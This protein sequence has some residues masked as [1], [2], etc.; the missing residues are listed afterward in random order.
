MRTM[1]W[2]TRSLLTPLMLVL[3]I[4][5]SA[6]PVGATETLDQSQ[7]VSQSSSVVSASSQ[8]AQVFT[9]GVYGNLS[10]V[11]LLLE[12]YVDNPPAGAFL[13]VGV[14]TVIGGLPSGKQIGSG[15]VLLSAVGPLGSA[16]WVDVN[17]RSAVVN[18]GAQ[19]ALVLQTSPWNAHV[20]WWYAYNTNYAG[21]STV[22]NDGTAWGVNELYDFTFKTYVIPD[23]L[24]QACYELNGGV[25]GNM[26]GQTFTPGLSGTLDRVRVYL[27]NLTA[28]GTLTASIQTVEKDGW[29]PSRVQIGG[30]SVPAAAIPHS[31][32]GWVE[33]GISGAVLNAGTKYAIVL[34][35]QTGMFTW[36]KKNQLY[37]PGGIM[38]WAWSWNNWTYEVAEAVFETYIATPLVFAP[39]PPPPATITPCSSGVCP[40]AGGLI[41]P[42]DSPAR[43]TSLV[44]FWE[45]ANGK[46]QGMLHFDDSRT[47]D[48]VLKGCGT[49]SAAC[50]LTVE[51]FACTDEHAI[52]IGGTY[53]PKKDEV[54][55]YVLTMSGVKKE[56]GTFAL[57]TGDYTYTVTHKGIVDV[58][59]PPAEGVAGGRRR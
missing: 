44:Q 2:M 16:G 14:Q 46:I 24:D 17:I 40:S 36:F 1:R 34:Y 48:F 33:I 39:P 53:T 37:Y 38:L 10:R 45:M 55:S 28:T 19:Y 27:E 50:R 35:A 49:S 25:A 3:V 31:G 47:G 8:Q 4:V 41:N 12:N 15:T 29:Y 57:T 59:C 9:A 20:K 5:A 30:G 43:V 56:I 26:M 22:F 52:R 51:D 18:A 7:T 42:P 54:A 32:P 13:T 23:T 6:A 58:T 21:G 11:S